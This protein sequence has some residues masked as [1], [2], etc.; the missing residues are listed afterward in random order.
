MRRDFLKA[1]R[2]F[3]QLQQ[4]ALQCKEAI[5]YAWS[6]GSANA[7]CQSSPIPSASMRSSGV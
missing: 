3:G 5:D 4:W 2:A 1:G 6:I 7:R